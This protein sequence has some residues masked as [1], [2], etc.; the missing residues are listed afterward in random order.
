MAD[1]NDLHHVAAVPVIDL[2]SEPTE[3]A[4]N[5]DLGPNCSAEDCAEPVVANPSSLLQRLKSPKPS[6]LSRKRTVHCN[7]PKGKKRSQG[8]SAND[9]KSV[10]PLQRVK[11]HD[12]ECLCVSNKRL[13]CK[14]CREELSLVSSSVNNHI[15]SAKHQA[16]KKRLELKEKREMDIAEALKVADETSCPVGQSLPQ[17]QRI[18]RV[19]VVTAFL[20]AGVPLNKLDCFRELLEEHAHRLTDRRHMSDLIPVIASQEQSLIKEE[21]KGK[22]ISIIFDGTTRL[23]EAMAILVRYVDSEWR[24]QQHLVRLQLIAKSM[25]GEEI[26]RELI[27][28]LSVHYSMTSGSL[29]GAMR[30]RAAVNN[31]A[32]RTL[33]VVYPDVLDVGCFSH[34]LDLVGRKVN[35]PHLSEFVMAWVS[36]FS[37][38]PKARLLWKEQTGCMV[39]SYS[40]TRWWSKWEVM[41]QLLEVYGDV[42]RFLQSHGDLPALTYSKLVRFF[43]DPQLKAYLQL[44]LAVVVDFGLPFV[45]A[46]YQLEGDGALALQCYEVISSLSTAVNMTT[47]HYPN[48]KAV[49]GRQSGGNPGL[50]QQLWQYGTACV[51]PAIVYFKECLDGCLKNPLSAFKAARLFSPQKV[52]EMKPDTTAVDGLAV[53][54]FLS[55]QS[56]LDSL[57]TELPQYLANAEDI[58]SD[59]SPLEFWKGRASI[60]PVWS[61]AAKKVLVVQPSS[62]ASERVFSLLNSSFSSYQESSLQDY[63]ETSLMLQYNKR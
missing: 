12:G 35:A 8:R 24:I 55:G 23:G 33:K 59:Y 29:L 14:A 48:L 16:G 38:S 11:E 9:P 17:D 18:F 62:A 63:I 19:K 57:K 54:P 37:H 51:Q 40:P 39:K 27:S 21:L 34:T 28:V 25:T 7:P 2:E 46:T 53:F 15:K 22:F 3:I 6:E 42:E 52:A 20:R 32:M 49:S 61:N 43:T 60:L 1:H 58:S 5:V 56:T 50:Q 31:V 13:F 4:D 44:E 30:D 26:A 47:P 36:L 10:T 45:Q 41:K